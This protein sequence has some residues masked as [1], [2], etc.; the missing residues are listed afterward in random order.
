MYR[1]AI[2]A[3][4]NGSNAQR[5]AE[6]FEGSG[7]AIVALILSNNE[8]AYVLK[9]AANLGIPFKTF[10]RKLFYQS[11][12]VLRWCQ[13]ASIDL[14]VL[15]GFLWLMPEYFVKAYPMRILNIHP[16][17]LP[18]YGGKGMYGDRVHS[19]VINAGEKMSGITI[20]F[21]DERYDNGLIV[22]QATCDVDKEDTPEMLA[23]K[24]HRLE[25]QYFPSVIGSILKEIAVRSEL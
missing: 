2:F 4:G 23:H 7:F 15:A 14:V 12:E 22:F 20:H 11:D 9:R 5:I 16:A 3:S 19:A 8:N 13:D 17:L 1:I 18:K 21:V 24:I 6:Y 25:H 10:D